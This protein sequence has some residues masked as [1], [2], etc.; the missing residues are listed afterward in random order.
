MCQWFFDIDPYSY[1]FRTNK[2]IEENQWVNVQQDDL[3][4]TSIVAITYQSIGKL[5]DGVICLHDR[6][7]SPICLLITGR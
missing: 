1:E 2:I 7:L 4:K 6:V 5:I 3:T